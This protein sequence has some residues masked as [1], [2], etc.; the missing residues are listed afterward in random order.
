VVYDITH[1]YTTI[2]VESYISSI[3]ESTPTR[4]TFNF[5]TPAG[6]ASI[7]IIPYTGSIIGDNV[8]LGRVQLSAPGKDY[9]TTTTEAI[10]SSGGVG[11]NLKLWAGAG[12]GGAANGKVYLGTG[13]A[14]SNPLSGSGTGTSILLYNRATGEITFGD[15]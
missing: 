10:T 14:G 3:N 7:A 12:G 5:T 9:I 13:S 8:Y 2:L 4:L 11:G 6:C 1:G 15:K